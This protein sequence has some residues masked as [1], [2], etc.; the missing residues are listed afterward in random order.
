MSPARGTGVLAVLLLLLSSL[1]AHAVT[2]VDYFP[3]NDGDLRVFNNP[4]DGT[5]LYDNV[6]AT[7]A[8][9]VNVWEDRVT[10]QNGDFVIDLFWQRDATATRSI[11]GGDLH[12]PQA[13]FSPAITYPSD[14]V[15][16]GPITSTGTVV[17]I[18]GATYTYNLT[19]ESINATVGG[20]AGCVQLLEEVTLQVGPTVV[21]H[22]T[23]REWRQTGLGLVAV[24]PDVAGSPTT[25]YYLL[26]ANVGGTIYG[27][28]VDNMRPFFPLNAGDRHTNAR[29][30]NSG[31]AADY[32]DSKVGSPTSF[33]G[34]TA[35]PFVS[36]RSDKPPS[37][38]Y[39]AVDGNN[40][41]NWAGS[42]DSGTGDD[43]WT[44]PAIA[45]IPQTV[46]QGQHIVTT[47]TYH[48]GA[49]SGTF[50]SD[51]EVVQIGASVDTQAGHFDNCVVLRWSIEAPTGT[52]AQM[53]DDTLA[54]GAG[55]VEAVPYDVSN[56]NSPT[57]KHTDVL[58]YASVGGT[59]YGG[60]AVDTTNFFALADA[61]RRCY[62]VD[63]GGVDD[64]NAGASSPISGIT[65]WPLTTTPFGAATPSR[66]KWWGNGYDRTFLFSQTNNVG[67]RWDFSPAPIPF[68]MPIAFAGQ[69]W[70][71]SGVL[72]K[73]NVNVGTFA[74][75]AS[76]D[77][78]DGGTKVPA[79]TF[80]SC[81]RLTWTL[82]LSPSGG[83]VSNVGE[84][85]FLAKGVGPV[86]KL[87][88]VSVPNVTRELAYASIGATTRGSLPVPSGDFN[89]D[90]KVDHIDAETML[91]AYL[92][93][94]PAYNLACDIYPAGM[95]D[96]VIDQGDVAAFIRAWRVANP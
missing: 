83:S 64:V 45:L 69:K 29:D 13:Q 43:T 7:T 49:V 6:S 86:Y 37:T 38:D 15:V 4:D 8:F 95:P 72:L 20:F 55:P 39:Y 57:P 51:V 27:A 65:V 35:Y 47:G 17:G 48:Q 44:E 41:L 10:K 54:S 70:A 14:L 67:D 28:K 58:A 77:A 59:T 3:F 63:S 50:R 25:V 75:T 94:F 36:T 73:S 21:Y 12:P 92:G 52:L 89:A 62:V 78:I 1:Q 32:L 53:V 46:Y 81:V 16:G 71:T 93:G 66:T 82:T 19:V 31:V 34:S 60:P 5:I 40:Q 96:G 88:T 23:S 84:T 18:T 56:P 91:D 85:W 26:Y 61:L 87:D 80:L 30:L 74:F 22:N 68:L 90:T 9:T 76:I 79:G 24:T 42:H 33:H 2:T 11:L